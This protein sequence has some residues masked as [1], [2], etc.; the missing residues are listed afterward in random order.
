M[1]DRPHQVDQLLMDD[2]HH[3]LARVERLQST[4]SPTAC[5][6]TRAMKSLTTE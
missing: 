3:L 4:F 2:A 5:S 1:I 6:V